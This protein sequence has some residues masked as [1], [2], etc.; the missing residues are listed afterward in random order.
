MRSWTSAVSSFGVVV[1]GEGL[2][3]FS[4]FGVLPGVPEP[5]KGE[6]LPVAQAVRVGLL[7]LQ[8]HLLSLVEPSADTRHRRFS[9]GPRH[10]A[11][12]CTV[13]ALAFIVENPLQSARLL[14]K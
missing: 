14:A 12:S 3:L 2:Q 4:G 6:R 1:N 7:R 5:G 13:S 10:R 9:K 11:F 8:I